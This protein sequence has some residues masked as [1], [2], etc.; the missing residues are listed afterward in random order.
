MAYCGHCHVR[1]LKQKYF[2]YILGS[3]TI[4]PKLDGICS[5]LWYLRFIL[6]QHILTLHDISLPLNL[7]RDKRWSSESSNTKSSFSFDTK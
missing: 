6:L 5:I 3:A 4:S 2:P 7:T 1:N